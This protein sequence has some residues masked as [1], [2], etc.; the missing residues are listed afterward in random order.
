MSPEL[1]LG[2]FG[3]LIALSVAITTIWQSVLTR[4]HNRL[5]VKPILQIYRNTVTGE[6]AGI[7]LR[8]N[9]VGPAIIN[10]VEFMVDELTI[11]ANVSD[12]W[13]EVLNRIDLTNNRMRIEAITS[14][15]SLS[16]GEKMPFY[17]TRHQVEDAAEIDK[18]RT[19]FDR[20]T[21]HIEYES[22]YK[23]VMSIGV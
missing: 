4:R 12:P 18:L 8:N 10:S 9:G 5:S 11:P 6:H 19:A 17:M 22:V 2:I 3:T 7:I 21:I 15:E 14:K 23:G 1:L 16:A 20:I 13:T